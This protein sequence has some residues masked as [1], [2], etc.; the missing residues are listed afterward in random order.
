MLSVSW[1]WLLAIAVGG[2]AFGN[3]AL[4]GLV[5]LHWRIYVS[6]RHQPGEDEQSL[7]KHHGFPRNPYQ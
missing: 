7:G 5:V 4:I 6:P 1:P 2:W 3:L